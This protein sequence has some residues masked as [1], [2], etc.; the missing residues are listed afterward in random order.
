METIPRARIGKSQL[1]IL[2]SLMKILPR[3]S[4][5]G[6]SQLGILSSLMKILPRSS[7]IG[8]FSL[9]LMVH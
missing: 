4:R 5:I 3:S 6:K 1:G 9:I 2:S 8:M 7:R